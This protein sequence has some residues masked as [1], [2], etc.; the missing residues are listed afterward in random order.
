MRRTHSRPS[1]VRPRSPQ[2]EAFVAHRR[3]IPRL[4]TQSLTDP[5]DTVAISSSHHVC[6]GESG[7]AQIGEGVE[8]TKPHRAFKRFN[9]RLRPGRKSQHPA[10]LPGPTDAEIGRA[11]V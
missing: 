9:S 11:H 1:S 7:L 10:A 8:G 2:S 5:I 6:E 3:R 4:L